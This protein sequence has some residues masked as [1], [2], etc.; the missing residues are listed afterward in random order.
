MANTRTQLLLRIL[1]M[2]NSVS[3][4]EEK[5]RE[6]QPCLLQWRRNFP[7]FSNPQSD[8]AQVVVV[9]VVVVV[10]IF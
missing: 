1:R 3:R 10:V 6:N 9:V 8:L 2:S 4:K 5:W 7:F